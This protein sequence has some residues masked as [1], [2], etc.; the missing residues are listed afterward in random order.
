MLGPR[1]RIRDGFLEEA[2]SRVSP[3]GNR[4]AL[5]GRGMHCRE[6]ACIAGLE[7]PP[8]P[9]RTA[10]EQREAGR[11]LEHHPSGRACTAP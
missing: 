2:A 4:H 8:I 1:Q 3:E 7:H 6:E 10:A 5:Q 11:G 9:G